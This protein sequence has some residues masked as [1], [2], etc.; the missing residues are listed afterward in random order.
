MSLDTIP[1]P[2]WS[3]LHRDHPPHFPSSLLHLHW[4]LIPCPGSLTS[5]TPVSL[6]SLSSFPSAPKQKYSTRV[7]A[8][9]PFS[10]GSAAPVS[11]GTLFSAFLLVGA[12][13]T[14]S[15]NQPCLEPTLET[16]HP[17]GTYPVPGLPNSVWQRPPT[18]ASSLGAPLQPPLSSQANTP[19]VQFRLIS[20]PL[21]PSLHHGPDS[22]LSS[23]H[24]GVEDTNQ[25]L[26]KPLASHLEIQPCL[27]SFL[28]RPMA[29][30]N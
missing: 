13:A 25:C 21:E 30:S 18:L 10:P 17:A 14:S 12:L 3:L 8:H 29:T 20:L 11:P 16:A 6:T 28:A 5:I 9:S 4:D 19:G 22:Q 1:H 15:W 2:P 7:Q 23:C 27:I 26:S 24:W